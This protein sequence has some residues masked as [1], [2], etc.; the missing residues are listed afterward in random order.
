MVWGLR[1]LTTVRSQ[2]HALICNSSVCV[3]PVSPP[4]FT[5]MCLPSAPV[6]PHVRHPCPAERPC[7]GAAMVNFAVCLLGRG[8]FCDTPGNVWHVHLYLYVIYTTDTCA[9]SEINS[10][11]PPY[12]PVCRCIRKDLRGPST[13]FGTRRSFACGHYWACLLSNR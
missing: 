8:L 6:Q 5:A 13:T 11:E 7:N 12:S 10:C 2:K 4:I 3:F 9:L 1:C